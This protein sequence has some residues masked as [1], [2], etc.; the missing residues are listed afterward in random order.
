M[1]ST[2]T[3]HA[4][5][6]GVNEKLDRIVRLLMEQGRRV[7][8]VTDDVD[9]VAQFPENLVSVLE[10]DFL[11]PVVLRKARVEFA[12]TAIVLADTLDRSASD[13]D[14]RSVLATLAVERIK[15]E[16]RTVVEALTEDAAYHLKNAGVDEI[17]QSG[18]LTAEMLAFS[19]DH[20]RYS[21]SLGTLMRFVH[22]N[23][24]SRAKA[25]ER[26]H[27]KAV[28]EVTSTLALERKILLAV[29]RKGKETLDPKLKIDDDDELL[30]IEIL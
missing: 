5:I 17:I 21:E 7:V 4:V 30:Y 15:P 23:R 27:G 12:T 3:D 24:I 10:G 26:H 29:V 22:A 2:F 11:D 14:A 25:P 28:A 13:A 8:V 18:E 20:P 1:V 9:R 19:T 6:L 16:I